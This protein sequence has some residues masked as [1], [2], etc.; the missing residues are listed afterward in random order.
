MASS[1]DVLSASTKSFSALTLV[2]VQIDGVVPIV[3]NSS[4]RLAGPPPAACA[5]VSTSRKGSKAVP[6]AR[7]LSQV[8]RDRFDI[9]GFL[10]RSHAAR[11]AL[12]SRAPSRPNAGQSRP[13]GPAPLW[14]HRCTDLD[15]SPPTR[16][17]NTTG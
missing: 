5:G 4:T 6:A 8:R 14:S 10:N 12:S 2:G 9:V 15:P 11:S 1:G 3:Q 13:A 17:Q 7:V 16:T